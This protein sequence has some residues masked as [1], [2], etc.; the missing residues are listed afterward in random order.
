MPMNTEI[1]VTEIEDA[2]NFW[3]RSSPSQGEELKLCQQAS[4]LA[5]PYA[6]LIMTK[7]ASVNITELDAMAQQAI[8][9]WR[10][11]IGQR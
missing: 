5:E 4:A 1:S 8:A 7:R 9:D 3:R 11:A 2:I 6:M 10:V